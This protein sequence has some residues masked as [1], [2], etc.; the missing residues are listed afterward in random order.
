M[1]DLPPAQRAETERWYGGLVASL[2][3][4]DIAFADPGGWWAMPD[5]IMN[6]YAEAGTLPAVSMTLPQPGTSFIAPGPISMTA[7]ASCEG[8]KISKV[9]FF[10]GPVED[11][12]GDRRAL[13]VRLERL[14]RQS[15]L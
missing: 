4:G 13:Q 11:W 5:F 15:R 9:E 8:K 12:P 14:P 3:R 6:A 10:A 1:I 7:S 2:K